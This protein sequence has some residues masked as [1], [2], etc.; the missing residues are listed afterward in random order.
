MRALAV[1]LELQGWGSAKLE[2]CKATGSM[3]KNAG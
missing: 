1:V 2:H 3:F